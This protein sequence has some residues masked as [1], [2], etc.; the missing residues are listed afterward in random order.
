MAS[1]CI[2]NEAEIC[3]L[4]NCIQ[5]VTGL[6]SNSASPSDTWLLEFKPGTK[7]IDSIGKTI[8]IPRAFCKLF[9]E[10]SSLE[11]WLSDGSITMEM[12]KMWNPRFLALQGLEYELQFSEF[13]QNNIINSRKSPHFVRTFS[14]GKS[15]KFEDLN[16]TLKR[17]GISYSDATL[18]RNMYYSLNL[19]STR[20]SISNPTLTSW[21]KDWSEFNFAFLLSQQVD[22]R[23]SKTF[24][25]WILSVNNEPDFLASLF[26]VLFQI[27]QACYAL[28]S[29]RACHNDLHAGNVWVSTRPDVKKNVKYV[30]G[31]KNYVFSNVTILSRLFDFDRAYAESLGPN[32]ILESG[33]CPK[34]GQCNKIIEPKDFIKFLCYATRLMRD[35]PPLFQQKIKSILVERGKLTES[36]ALFGK[37]EI[38]KCFPSNEALPDESFREFPS[39]PT[40]LD[41]IYQL[42]LRYST[43]IPADD[44]HID[45]QFVISPFV[46]EEE[47]KEII[48]PVTPVSIHSRSDSASVRYESEKEPRYV[49][50]EEKIGEL[51]MPRL[52]PVRTVPF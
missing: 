35:Q 37:L 41:N 12:V 52:S 33:I 21:P 43:D 39:Y 20:P 47:E 13:V 1:G 4:G 38:A 48:H 36:G 26:L 15:C 14:I 9:I 27:C 10:P 42:W 11:K 51:S 45:E 46:E 22:S 19:F 40:L 44:V 3:Q 29:E 49:R 32:P 30:I 50:S 16:K 6:P 2:L 5:K 31:S 34:H 17:G 25:K 8:E 24:E 23:W 7:Y 18:A 28:Y